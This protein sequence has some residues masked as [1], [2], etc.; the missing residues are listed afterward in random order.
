MTGA[1][2]DQLKAYK[3]HF[4]G[5]NPPDTELAGQRNI[6]ADQIVDELPFCFTHTSEID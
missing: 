5:G 6:G 4:I 1:W 2:A 3:Y